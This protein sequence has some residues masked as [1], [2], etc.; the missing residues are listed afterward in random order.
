M[1]ALGVMLQLTVQ[2]ES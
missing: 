2:T 1:P